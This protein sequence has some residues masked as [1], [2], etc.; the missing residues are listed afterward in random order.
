MSNASRPAWWLEG[1]TEQCHFCQQHY[2]YE[3]G[4]F[5]SHCDEAVCP[6]CVSYQA[7]TVEAVCPNCGLPRGGQS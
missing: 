7:T 5:C 2:H 6:V 1:G 4:Y 3:A